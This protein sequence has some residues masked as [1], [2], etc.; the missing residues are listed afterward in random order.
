[1]DL[2]IEELWSPRPKFFDGWLACHEG[3]ERPQVFGDNRIVH[4]PTGFVNQA[5][6]NEAVAHV[7]K[8]LDSREVRDVRFTLG[9]DASGEPSIFFGI[10]LTPYASHHSRLAD[11]TGRVA[12]V[13]F[14][15]LQPY[16]QWGLQPYFNFTSDQAHF[17]NPG[18]M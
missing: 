4:V 8:A 1:V 12:T 11:V 10:L 5:E 18:W 2:F 6:L 17:R 15:Q 9:S 3:R 14:D 16:N 7:A 13:L